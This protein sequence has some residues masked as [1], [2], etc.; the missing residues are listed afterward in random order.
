MWLN[1]GLPFGL[2]KIELVVIL[3]QI[4]KILSILDGFQGLKN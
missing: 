3:L 4:P 2:L 1:V